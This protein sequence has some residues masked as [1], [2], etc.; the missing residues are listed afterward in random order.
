MS[1]ILSRQAFGPSCPSGGTWY[2][3]AS[4]SKF[5]GCC[6]SEP[7][8]HG[9][10][11]GNLEPA[12][13]DPK[14]YGQFSDQQCSSGSWYT[15]TGTSPPFLGC[16]KSNP[17]KSGCPITDLAAGFLSSNPNEAA[18]FLSS[19][20]STSGS[21]STSASASGT[22]VPASI[23]STSSTAAAAGATLTGPAQPIVTSAPAH[24]TSVGAIAGG[25]VGG[26]A[27]LAILVGLLLFYWRRRSRKSR[28]RMD[29]QRVD[30]SKSPFSVDAQGGEVAKESKLGPYEGKTLPS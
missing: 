2:A 25:T 4:G 13:F 6:N 17:C 12:S 29:T 18:G 15:C 11:A 19:N 27:V 16:C 3:C 5:V 8:S 1:L 30:P 20:S 9:C 26:V 10:P 14:Y 7:C 23:N 24:N 28:Q 22:A 21:T